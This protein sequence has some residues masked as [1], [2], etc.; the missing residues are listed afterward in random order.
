[1][2]ERIIV[3]VRVH[4]LFMEGKSKMILGKTTRNFKVPGK[5]L[6]LI[7][8]DSSIKLKNLF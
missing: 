8:P 7:D 4:Q 6:E 2:G 5:K 1:M 3:K